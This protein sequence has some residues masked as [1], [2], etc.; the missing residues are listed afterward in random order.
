[1]K[2]AS[3]KS[4]AE[5]D[6]SAQAPSTAA[7]L[8][9]GVV[10][11]FLRMWPY[12]VTMDYSSQKAWLLGDTNFLELPSVPCKKRHPLPA[13]PPWRSNTNP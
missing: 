4:G 11:S 5:E 8:S 9:G 12:L 1:M 7:W 10:R 6:R 2:V 3:L 13:G